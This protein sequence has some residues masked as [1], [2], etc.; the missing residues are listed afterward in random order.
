MAR[1]WIQFQK[2]YSLTQFVEEYGTEEQCMDA[3]F[4]WRWPNGFVCPRC[5]H[6]GYGHVQSRALYQCHGCRYQ[7]SL[8]AGT[9]LASTKLA[10]RTWF[11]AMYLMTQTKNG[12]SALELSRQLGVS[13][14]TAWSLK[15]KLMQ[16]M[17]E[18]DDTRP[19]G[20]SVQ[21][22]DAYWGGERRGSKRGR[23]APGKTPF[24]AAVELNPKGRPVRM[25]LSR[26]GAFQSDEIAAWAKCHLEPGTVVFSDALG[27]FPAVQRAGC[28]HQPFT[29]GGGPASAKHPAL[30]WVNTLLGNLKRSM[31]GSYH[32]VSSK[33]LPR[34]LA[35][36]SYRFNRRFSLPEM[37]PRLAY[38]ALRTPP[39]PNRVL[40]LAENYA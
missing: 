11:M 14:N 5:E 29:T 1:N 4:R 23:G 10:L 40:K 37:F 8:T 13:Y 27:C 30:S 19:L 28:F 21:L 36:F 6:T 9:I 38:V 31:H 22:D 24:V 16:V 33:H 15:H 39:M 2:G 7:V 12:I 17:K 35:E 20:G 3:L 18:R 34:Y 25:R 32:H 26:V